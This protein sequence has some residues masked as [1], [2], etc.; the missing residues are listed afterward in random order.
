MSTS[1]P[2]NDD[3]TPFTHLSA[4]ETRDAVRRLA[5][6]ELRHR[7][8]GAC[9]EGS[10]DPARDDQCDVCTLLERLDAP[11]DGPKLAQ[12]LN[13]CAGHFARN[14]WQWTRL[15]DIEAIY[16]KSDRDGYDALRN[17][18]KRAFQL[19]LLPDKS[20]LTR[21]F[22]GEDAPWWTRLRHDFMF[23]VYGFRRELQREKH[24]PDGHLENAGVIAYWEEDGEYLQ[25]VQP[26]IGLL[27]AEWLAA[28]PDNKH[29]RA[30][31]AE[32]QRIN[33]DY[34]KRISE[35]K[36]DGRVRTDETPVADAAETVRT[37]TA[38]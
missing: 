18:V 12:M 7:Y 33:D 23:R 3:T 6:G 8:E 31:F 16:R 25:Y 4:D 5:A 34:A 32:M 14:D 37:A 30:I 38:E 11:F 36:V 19:G 29:A 10:D 35:G 28:E 24:L 20:R 17:R 9:P 27:L 21:M 26:S 2:N 22:C 1:A 15:H 13:S